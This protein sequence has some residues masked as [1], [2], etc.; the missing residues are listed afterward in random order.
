[1]ADIGDVVTALATRLRIGLAGQQ[2]AGRVYEYAPDSVLPPTAIVL[3]APS[4]FVSY[5]VTMDGS[6]EFALVVRV[7]AEAA[8]DRTSQAQLLT[9]FARAG[10]ASLRAAIYGDQTLG[11]VVSWTRVRGGTVYGDLEWAGV[12]Y[13][14]GELLVECAS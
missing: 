5:D 9:Y 13:F 12:V 2:I 11:G 4:D 7:L 14:G 6:D 3:P 10:G 8:M 1:M